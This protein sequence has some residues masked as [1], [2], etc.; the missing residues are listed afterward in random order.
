MADLDKYFSKD[1]DILDDREKLI[2]RERFGLG[3]KPLTSLEEV[4][5]IL[6]LSKERI[7]QIQFTALEKLRKV[8]VP[9]VS[10]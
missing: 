10:S 5:K 9:A 6:N 4:G 8:L 1:C 7:R 2:L 3:D